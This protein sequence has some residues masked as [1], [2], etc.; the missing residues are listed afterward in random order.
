[1]LQA[2]LEG[3]QSAGAEVETVYL[4]EKEIRHCTGCYSCWTKTPGVCIHRDDM[5]VLLDKLEKAEIVVFAT[6]LY[7][8][9]ATGLMKDFIDRT[10]PLLNANLELAEG[11]YYHK[12]RFSEDG[13]K[14]HVLM[15]NCGFP[16]RYNFSNLQETFKMILGG[17]LDASILCSEGELLRD[18]HEGLQSLISHYLSAVRQAGKELVQSG[19]ISPDT[20]SILDKELLDP[21]MYLQA[22]NS[23]WNSF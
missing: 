15:S 7:F 14:K 17:T 1:M 12:K 3:A 23:Y 4:A 22:A 8:F 5:P 10:L 18:G 11:Q 21:K 6:P 16:G 9:N 13:V 2:F 19:S 20:Q